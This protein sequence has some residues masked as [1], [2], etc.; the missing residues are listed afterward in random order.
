MEEVSQ[1]KGEDFGRTVLMFRLMRLFYA[2]LVYLKSCGRWYAHLHAL[3]G[4]GR[5]HLDSLRC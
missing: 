1:V 3:V 5:G 2:S 4:C